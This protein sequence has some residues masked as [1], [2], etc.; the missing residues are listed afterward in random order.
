MF[1]TEGTT[2]A[3]ARGLRDF[4][5]CTCFSGAKGRVW[6]TGEQELGPED[7]VTESVGWQSKEAEFYSGGSQ[8]NSTYLPAEWLAPNQV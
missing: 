5:D 7:E 6:V 2:G 1:Q 4:R 3:K 8:A